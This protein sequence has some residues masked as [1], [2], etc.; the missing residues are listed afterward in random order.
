MQSKQISLW[1]ETQDD[2]GFEVFREAQAWF[3][4]SN[5]AILFALSHRYLN[6]VLSSVMCRIDQPQRI[7]PA[8]DPCKN[9]ATYVARG[10]IRAG[11]PKPA[12]TAVNEANIR[13]QGPHQNTVRAVC[14]AVEVCGMSARVILV[15]HVPSAQPS[16]SIMNE[17]D[18]GR[19]E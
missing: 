8:H 19:Y 15:K 3:R 17:V 14:S 11:L 7:V 1:R 9:A 4:S 16:S 2:A 5:A 18:T 13:S 10:D 6:L 12:P